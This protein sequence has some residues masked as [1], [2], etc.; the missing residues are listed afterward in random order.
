MCILE[1]GK[2]KNEN[3]HASRQ[4]QMQTGSIYWQT[5]PVTGNAFQD[6]HVP[7][8]ATGELSPHWGPPL[9]TLC[10]VMVNHHPLHPFNCTLVRQSHKCH[11]HGGGRHTDT[12][13]ATQRKVLQWGKWES[14]TRVHVHVLP[15]TAGSNNK[16]REKNYAVLVRYVRQKGIFIKTI[17]E[18]LRSANPL[19][20]VIMKP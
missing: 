9:L 18:R 14:G 3:V 8:K 10:G 7:W 13:K 15:H 16:T 17:H 6:P 12:A 4:Q 2:N 1:G 20:S 5:A 19:Q 11:I